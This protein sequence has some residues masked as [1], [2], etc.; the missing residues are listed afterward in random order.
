MLTEKRALPSDHMVRCEPYCLR[1][2]SSPSARPRAYMWLRV[3]L[4]G[5]VG[6]E[7]LVDSLEGL[8]WQ[9][10]TGVAASPGWPFD[11]LRLCGVGS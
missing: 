2:F 6:P 5:R 7:A 10:P 3:W 11:P 1:A 9:Y 8:E 4:T